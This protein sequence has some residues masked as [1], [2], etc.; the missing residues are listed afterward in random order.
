MTRVRTFLFAGVA[1]LLM[2]G[3][4]CGSSSSS[5]S[6]SSANA[7]LGVTTTTPPATTQSGDGGGGSDSGF[8]G[9]AKKDVQDLQREDA[10]LFA[11]GLSPNAIKTEFTNLQ[12][13]YAHAQSQAPAAIKPD[14]AVIVGFIGKLNHVLASNNYNLQIAAPQLESLASSTQLKQ[15]GAHL[16]AWA[17][18][19]CGA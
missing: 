10:S 8:C 19:N 12:N 6:S 18:A 17:V 9:T 5:G 16:K 1:V 15:A 13:A 4:A 3:A 14:L 2:A 11:G 7:G